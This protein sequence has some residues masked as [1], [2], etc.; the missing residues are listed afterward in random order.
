M[1]Q[2]QLVERMDAQAG[3]LLLFVADKSI[4]VADALGAL[5]LKLR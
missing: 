3:D 5:R 1:Q 4:V 2:T